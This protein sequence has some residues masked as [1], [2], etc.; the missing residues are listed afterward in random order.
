MVD[1]EKAEGK[2]VKVKAGEVVLPIIETDAPEGDL[3][4]LYREGKR[5]DIDP[6]LYNGPFIDYYWDTQA[7]QA[8]ERFVYKAKSG[9]R[10]E[11]VRKIH[12]K[13]ELYR[14]AIMGPITYDHIEM[15]KT[16]QEA[17]QFL[18]MDN[19]RQKEA[20]EEDWPWLAC[21]LF[22]EK[23]SKN[24]RVVE[25]LQEAANGFKRRVD[26][27][28]NTPLYKTRHHRMIVE[29]KVN[30]AQT[31]EEAVSIYEDFLPEYNDEVK[32]NE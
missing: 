15:L 5:Y 10:Q 13:M 2:Y 8:V 1:R 22:C 14:Y 21:S 31:D 17:D 3:R 23:T 27:N 4:P 7:K 28:I 6:G 16:E 20:A 18:R 11:L 32:D 30:T 24:G 29:Y 25:T 19:D 9:I 12:R 26:R